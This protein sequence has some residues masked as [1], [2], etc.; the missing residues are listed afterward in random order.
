MET[1]LKP[2]VT[3]RNKPD[4]LKLVAVI[5]RVTIISSLFIDIGLSLSSVFILSIGIDA[6]PGNGG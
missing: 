1:V 3:I 2:H 5:L 4:E 6:V